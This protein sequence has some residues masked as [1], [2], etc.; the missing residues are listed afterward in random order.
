MSDI[1]QRIADWRVELAQSQALS[2]ADID[3][4]ENHLREEVGHLQATDLSEVEA[5]LVA[6][7]RLG[8]T[9]GL[10]GEF[11][12]VNGD[13]R[14][15][16]L[17]SW[18]AFGVLAYLLVGFIATGISQGCIVA[19]TLLGLRGYPLGAVALVA[20]VMAIAGFLIFMWAMLSNWSRSSSALGPSLMSRHR[21]IALLLA[22]AGINLLLIAGQVLPQLVATRLLGPAEFGRIAYVSSYG[23]L[24][25]RLLGP[26]ALAA[27]V[28][29]FRACAR[30]HRGACVAGPSE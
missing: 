6:R 18:M 17:L 8:D 29:A 26:L 10:A 25:W 11:R 30:R 13:R 4:L 15:L 28:I 3:E 27:A 21:P 5:F 16:E 22:L 14:P 7:H 2:A 1:E 12:K 20:R 23:Y 24:F 9:G 19:A